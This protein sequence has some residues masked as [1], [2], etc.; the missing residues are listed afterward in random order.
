M[1]AYRAGASLIEHGMPGQRTLRPQGLVVAL[2]IIR[3]LVGVAAVVIGVLNARGHA[4]VAADAAAWGLP[5]P[6]LATWLG[7]A[8]LIVFGLGLALGLATRLCALVVLLVV[9]VLV[10]TAGR[11]EG[12]A[13]LF[14]GALLAAGCLVLLTRGGGARQLLDRVDPQEW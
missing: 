4:A 1:S 3:V 2:L 12:G 8:L 6:G 11:V 5:A 13:P 14:G 7:C 10:A 9:L